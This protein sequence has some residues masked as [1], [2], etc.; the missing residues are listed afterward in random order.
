MPRK[1]KGDPISQARRLREVQ[2]LIRT[3]IHATPLMAKEM[4]RNALEMID[5]IIAELATPAAIRRAGVFSECADGN[6]T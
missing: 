5:E 2:T 4:R 1:K 6:R 3:T